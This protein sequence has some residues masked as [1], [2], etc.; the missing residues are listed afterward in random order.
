MKPVVV[1]VIILLLSLILANMIGVPFGWTS[2]GKQIEAIVESYFYHL[3]QNDA[4][5][6]YAYRVP[7]DQGGAVSSVELEHWM[8]NVAWQG[9]QV[10]P[11]W[12]ILRPLSYLSTSSVEVRGKFHYQSGEARDFTVILRR[13]PSGW[14]VANWP[15]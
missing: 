6:A 12:T 3:A 4:I 1:V 7:I 10:E 9:V 13:L 8:E 15:A 2:E 5:K 14:R 11:T